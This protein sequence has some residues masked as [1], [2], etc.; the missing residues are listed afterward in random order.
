MERTARPQK[1]LVWLTAIVF[2]LGLMVVDAAPAQAHTWY[3]DGCGFTGT[4]GGGGN[5]AWANTREAESCRGLAAK[6]H[7]KVDGGWQW[8]SPLYCG[9]QPSNCKKIVYGADDHGASQHRGQ[10]NSY[11]WSGWKWHS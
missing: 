10:S 4:N 2:A 8:S 6:I 5:D 7:Y 3:H 11:S 9:G 1:A